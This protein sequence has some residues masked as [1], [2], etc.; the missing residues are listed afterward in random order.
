MSEALRQK[1]SARKVLLILA[2][3]L[4]AVLAL[5]GIASVGP[6]G[7]TAFAQTTPQ[8]TPTGT[9]IQFLNPSTDTS[10]EISDKNNNSANSAQQAYHLV[11][12]VHNAPSGSGVE[13]RYN[14][15]GD[16][17]PEF[18]IGRGVAVSPGDT[19]EYFWDIPA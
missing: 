14:P 7:F 9:S 17:T 18:T 19:F 6:G 5:Q 15:S 4:V 13:F 16:T 8:P 11:A 1:T 3:L 10:N 2:G 12:W